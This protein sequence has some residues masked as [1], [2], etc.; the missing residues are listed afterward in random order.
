M[1]ILLGTSGNDTLTGTAGS[2]TISGDRGDDILTGYSAAS[3]AIQITSIVRVSTTSDGEEA[4]NGDS[5]DAVFSPDGTKVA[6]DSRATNLVP[7]DTNSSNLGDFGPAPAGAT[8]VAY[9][10]DIF[11]KDLATGA[12]TRVSTAA[13]GSQANAGC[14]APVFS[15]D[16]TKVAFYSWSS[17]LVPGDNNGDGDLFIK[18]LISGAVTR[19][20]GLNYNNLPAE[21]HYAYD[22]PLSQ[23]GSMAVHITGTVEP[24]ADWATYVQDVATGALTLVTLNFSESSF[25]YPMT[26]SFSPTG[27]Q[28]LFTSDESSLVPGDNNGFVDVF[29]ATLNRSNVNGGANDTL[30][31]GAGIDS[32]MFSEARSA[33]T[34][35]RDGNHVIVAGPDGND[36]L[37]GIEKAVFADQTV[38]L[39]QGATHTDFNSDLN[40]DILWQN[41]DGTV[42]AWLMNGT[43]VVSGSAVGSNPGSSWH[44]KAGADF[45]GDGK[46]DILWQNEDGTP[47]IWLMDGTAV[48]SGGI[49]GFNPGAS[50]HVVGSGDFNGDGHA[51]ILWQDADGTP[52]V[53]LMNGTT[54]LSGT[55]LSNPGMSWHAIGSGD[56]N[57]DGNSDILWQNADGT[58][59]IWLMNGTSLAGGGAVGGNPG[60]QW[61]VKAAGDFNADGM[62][63]ILWQNADGTPV[64]WFMNGTTM[65]SG[66]VAGFNPGS[67]W[68]AVGAGDFNG[69]G[70][71]DIEWQNANGTPAVWLMDGT[72]L[73]SGAAFSNPGSAWHMLTMGS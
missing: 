29:V 3:D 21:F 39:G 71:A 30:N 42:A 28:L 46:A 14:F 38:L 61:H 73:L 36:A 45:N 53:W 44:V 15:L 33:Y 47:A 65:T 8:N 34:I 35:T 62:S 57:G 7:G 24:W 11:V 9:G 48:L 17:N 60:S 66:G 56:F 64:V 37:T 2:D 4:E 41:S 31:G 23:D 54:L 16:G 52:A 12:I 1:T 27:N 43:S 5:L 22:H 49:A 6:F 20:A 19:V 67:S 63:D 25:D 51:D 59:A 72:S 55:S 68:Q 70:K 26:A 69:D 32:A 13:D 10:S 50:W 40:A 58:A 18:D